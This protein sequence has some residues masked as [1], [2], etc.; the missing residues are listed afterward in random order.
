ED[1]WHDTSITIKVPETYLTGGAVEFDTHNLYIVRQDNI[2][3]EAVE[4]TVID[5]SA[6]PSICDVDPSA[7]PAGTE[8]T[9]YGERFGDEDGDV[10]FYNEQG[11][12][13]TASIWDE[14]EISSIPVPEDAATG[15]VYVITS[16]GYE[17]N[18]FTFAVGNCNEEADLCSDGEVCCQDG[19]CSTSCTDEVDVEAHYAYLISTATI[20]NAPSVL[21]QCDLDADVVSPSPWTGWSDPEDVCLNSAVTATFDM[22]M[23]TDTLNAST[24]TVELCVLDEEEDDPDADADTTVDSCVEWE[25]VTPSGFPTPSSTTFTW[26]PPLNDA[27]IPMFEADSWYRVTLSGGGEDGDIQAFDDDA[28]D[29]IDGAYLANDF[30]WEFWT[31][32]ST[33]PCDVGDV[34]LTPSEFTATTANEEV[35]YLAQLVAANDDCQILSCTGYTIVWDSDDDRAVIDDLE[36]AAGEC[37]NVVRAEEE[38]LAGYPAI[39]ES[40]V[41]NAENDPSDTA[42][43]TIDFIDP[44]VEEYFPDCSTACVNALPW[45]SF[46]TEMNWADTVSVSTVSLFECED[47]LC[48]P[49]EL[50]GSSLAT[51]IDRDEALNRLEIVLASNL[52]ANTWYRVILDADEITST[53]GV[54]LSEAG[55]N[56][57]SAANQ[58]YQD[59]FS[60]KFKTKDSDI[61][62]GIDSLRLSPDVAEMSYVGERE[63]FD[64]TAYG[65][66]DDCDP[67]GQALQGGEYEWDAWTAVDDPNNYGADTVVEEEIVAYMIQ[68][69]SIK[70]T[71]E[72]PEWC[73]TACLNIGA[74]V[75]SNDPVCGDTATDY[76]EECDDGNTSNGDGCSSEC[77]L[78]GSDACS[79]ACSDSGETC[80]ADSDCTETCDDGVCSIS[81]DS[82]ATDDGSDCPYY[83]GSCEIS[84]SAYC[85]GDGVVEAGVEECDDFG[86][87]SGDGCSASCLNEGS[88]SVD[89]VCGDNTVD[90]AP[91]AEVAGGE[92]CD[93]GNTTNG[94]GCS[95]QCLYEGGVDIDEVYAVCGDGD[96]DNGEDCDPGAAGLGDDTDGCSDACLNIGTTQCVWVCSGDGSS[97]SSD[98]DCSSGETCGEYSAPCCGNSSIEDGEDCDG[99]EDGEDGCSDACLSLGSSAY[100]DTASYCGDGD[101][102]GTGEECDAEATSS[103]NVGAYGVAQVAEGAPLEVAEETG[104]AISVVTA[105][106]DGVKGEAILQLECSCDTNASC[107]ETDLGCGTSNCCFDRPEVTEIYPAENVSGGVGVGDGY[108]RNTSL[109]IDFTAEMDLSSFDLSEDE[110]GDGV[111]SEDEFDGRVF[112]DLSSVDGSTVSA[113]EDCPTGY[114]A[115]ALGPSDGGGSLFVRAWSWVRD[116]VFGL[117]GSDVSASS[118]YTCLLP[119]SFES[120]SLSDGQRV[121]LRYQQLLEE[122]AIY[123]LV[124]LGDDDATDTVQEGAL[125]EFNVPLC[126]GSVCESSA[127][128]RQFYI[129]DEICALDAVS[130]EDIGNVNA[131]TYE[132]LSEE[133]FT[134]D[135]EEHEFLATPLTYRSSSSS[136]EE[137]SPISGLYEWEWSWGSEYES[138]EDDDVVEIASADLGDDADANFT[139]VG[140]D[141]DEAV[142]ATATV[143]VDVVS[144]TST[145]D[146]TVTGSLDVSALLCENPWPAFEDFPFVETDERTN[147]SFYY[148]RDAGEDGTADDLP[149]LEDPIDVT[150]LSSANILQELIFRVEGTSDAIG[151]RV[152][153]NE[154]YLSPEAWVEEQSFTGSF[155]ETTLDGY[156]A[157]E[158]GTTIYAAA[159]N[160]DDADIYPNMYIVSYNDNAEDEASAIFDEI[161]ENWSFNAN[162]VDVTDV[163]LC[164]VNGDY[165]LSESGS[166]VS[167]TWDGACLET[168]SENVCTLSGAECALDEGCP[169]YVDEEPT[170]DAEKGM[171]TRDMNRLTDLTDLMTILNDYGE[172]NRH[173]SVTKGQSCHTD[174]ECPG[175]ETCIEG[176]PTVQSGTFVPAISN[177]VWSSWNAVLGNDLGQ[178]LPEDPVNAFYHCVEDG[179]DAASCWNG[180]TGTFVCPDNSHLYA[181]QSAGG[182]A[183]TLYGVLESDIQ[184]GWYYDIDTSSSDDVTLSIEYPTDHAPST[185]NTGFA[186]SPTF[187]DGSTWGDSTICG[188]GVQGSGED[189]ELGDTDVYDC[190]DSSGDPGRITVSCSSSCDWYGSE[191]A[192][193]AAAEAS[194]S[195]CVP[196][197]CGNG[198]VDAGEQCDDG[199]NNGTYGYCGELC[200]VDSGYY[201]GDGYL[202]GGEAC[203]CGATG[204]Y[205]YSDGTAS[206]SDDDPVSWA[207]IYS[208]AVSNGQYDDDITTSCAFD[209]TAPGPSCGDGELNG[210]EACDGDYEEHEGGLCSDGVTACDT[211]SDCD[212]GVC[213]GTVSTAACGSGVVCENGP[214][215]GMACPLGTE[216]G[217]G[218]D[219]SSFEYDLFRYR[220]C[221]DDCSWPTWS[222]CVGGDQVCGNGTQEGD[223]ECDDGNDSNNDECLNTCELNVCGDDYVYSGVESCD[224]G[225]ENGELCEAGYE[226]T[227]NYCNVS[228]QY[229]TRSGAYCGDGEINGGE[230]C[231]GGAVAYSCIDT[232]TDEV[233]VSGSC[234]ATDN[235]TQGDCSTGYTCRWVG[236][237]NGGNTNGDPCTLQ[238][239]DGVGVTE[240]ETDADTNGCDGGACV[241]PTCGA[242]CASQCPFTYETTGLL[243][244]SEL[245]GASPTDSLDLYSYQNSDGDT[246]DN[247]ALYIPACS[248]ATQIAADVSNEDVELP[249][250][251]VVFVTDLSGSMNDAPG[252]GTTR[253]PNR[254]IDIVAESTSEAIEDLFDVFDSGGSTLKVGLVSYQNTSATTDQSLSTNESALLSMVEGY[255]DR[256]LNGTP[257][258]AGV[259][260]GI[261]I[262]SSGSGDVK[263]LILL[264]DGSPSYYLDGTGCSSASYAWTAEVGGG[265]SASGGAGCAAEV[266]YDSSLIGGNDHMVFYSA[267][268]SS[269]P[270]LKGYMAHESSE[271]CNGVNMTD[272]TECGSGAYAFAATTEEEIKEMYEAIVNSILNT[273]VSVTATDGSGVTHRTTGQVEV[274]SDTTI[275]FPTGFVCGSASQTIPLRNTYYGSGPM[276]FSNFTMTYCPYE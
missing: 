80:A 159:A 95:R 67:N 185:V 142:L 64:A 16:D 62:C 63:E 22:A 127:T 137:I 53:S 75:T 214:N 107:G 44:E 24:V 128:T 229:K 158:S 77:L 129:G 41:S 208:C 172:D 210:D 88:S 120:Q 20:P 12:D 225:T 32:A 132:S 222:A 262:L 259:S 146:E 133:L 276:N 42:E 170:C 233:D 267:V 273:T 244:Q 191:S 164:V 171:L 7:G 79:Y 116:L 156:H 154:G 162:E 268:I 188:D 221:A 68:S 13:V 189:C 232:S 145:E 72:L 153:P 272:A 269:D 136:V 203:D 43:L 108:C 201:C 176:Y 149:A 38:T 200:T 131:E 18:S 114:T 35:D 242:N 65:A 4:F 60:W 37:T 10:T 30:E 223:E 257:T 2:E 245:S 118:T 78:E 17:S 237:C 254:R 249:N 8:V 212:S 250:V 110:D 238:Y 109:Y 184:A 167:C 204:L 25:A 28:S 49:S 84:D 274:G 70:L 99:G 92:D 215:Q 246:P 140:N 90:Q 51:S 123:R 226:D 197:E 252:G 26:Y 166:Y 186:A 275:P 55:S 199:A 31:S 177:S 251:D 228:C 155:A 89:A 160:V 57:G 190:T 47:S 105:T 73:S 195:E 265:Y 94:D 144:E 263:I 36:P 11:A 213:G 54:P 256:A 98:A 147:F 224:D 148:C 194:G 48:E 248:V 205:D 52:S 112:I 96:I 196:Y 173:C 183:Y 168:C 143:T 234:D 29:A 152:I 163:N 27:L 241:A 187:C 139:A 235:G 5:D 219:C 33:D 266:R 151:V 106:A 161:L 119:V 83:S 113:A 81:G 76:G 255:T 87:E 86:S 102:D 243:I 23:D 93:D 227:C 45:A 21:V 236:V 71:S 192:A 138:T 135:E 207:G 260:Q 104:Y 74:P 19:T 253:A 182:E 40:T 124:V 157:I 111:I 169:L 180:A 97:C 181:Y 209:C 101:A 211:N 264:S 125:S 261:S 206:D 46:N 230:V 66:P 217:T 39:I 193:I 240:L 130:V 103:L 61:S 100:Y 126:I 122:E 121:Y 134:Q 117:F 216:C 258:A 50:I 69:G 85:C 271:E 91:V 178:A 115:L 150:S 14:E 198:V 59:S 34:I 270:N 247:A 15:P 58:Y 3:S 174:A 231:D 202:A 6:G 239:V 141:G 175:T 82:C 56:Y 1:Y 218:Y 179:Y 9:I 220:T 165:Y